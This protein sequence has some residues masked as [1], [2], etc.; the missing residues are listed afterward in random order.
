MTIHIQSVY[1]NLSFMYITIKAVI[2]GF[3]GNEGALIPLSP[4]GIRGFRE[5]KMINHV[6]QCFSEFYSPLDFC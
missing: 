1:T 3:K 6:L 2:R 4:F 5:E